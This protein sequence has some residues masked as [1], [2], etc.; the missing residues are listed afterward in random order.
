M[1]TEEYRTAIMRIVASGRE[2]SAI[3]DLLTEVERN[4]EL[5]RTAYSDTQARIKAIEKIA[6]SSQSPKQKLA[7]IKPLAD[8]RGDNN[9]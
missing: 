5:I 7:G 3:R 2:I 4:D 1:T 6:N 9:D 8:M